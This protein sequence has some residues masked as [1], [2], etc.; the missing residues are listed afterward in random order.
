MTK[1]NTGL[2]RAGDI[3]AT[4]DLPNAAPAP[5]DISPQLNKSLES[6]GRQIEQR[7][8]DKLIQLPLW[9]EPERGTPNSFLRSA[10]FAAIQGQSRQFLKE[11]T[12]ASSRDITVKYTGEQLNQD[13]LTVWENL[14]HL[15][16]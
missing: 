11:V 8:T 1:Q 12:L 5:P 6:L 16:R 7:E 2:S 15:A 13:D 9:F 3:F 14:V 4:L 10:L